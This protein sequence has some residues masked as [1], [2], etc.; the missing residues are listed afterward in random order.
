RGFIWQ[1]GRM[2]DLGVGG[3]TQPLDINNRGQVVGWSGRGVDGPQHAFL[4]QRGTVTWLT[5]GM[6][7]RATAINDRG[8]IAG[9]VTDWTSEPMNRAVRWYRGNMTYL[10]SLPGGNASTAVAINEHGTIL[11]TGNV[12]PYSVE[13]HAFLYSRATIRDLTPA[14]VPTEAAYGVQDINN[15]GQLLI[16]LAIYIPVRHR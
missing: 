13:E 1:N 6:G 4:W 7:S 9:G 10:G 15:H 8:Q 14:G 2:R 3:Y 12:A 16:G 11:G 5:T